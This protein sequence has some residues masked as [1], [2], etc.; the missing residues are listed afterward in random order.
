MDKIKPN[1][2]VSRKYLYEIGEIVNGYEVT[3]QTVITYKNSQTV[4]SYIC[5]CPKDGY[6]NNVNE[7]NLLKGSG[8]PVCSNRKIMKGVNDLATNRPDFIK[9]IVNK[10]DIYKYGKSSNKKVMM[11]CPDCNS[12]R[13]FSINMLDKLGKLPC[14]CSDGISYPNKFIMAFLEQLRVKFATEKRFKWLANRY[15]DFYIKDYNCIIEAHG[16][17]HYIQTNRKGAR[18]L[19]YEIA[20]DSLK[21]RNALENGIT[22]YIVLNCS[23]SDREFIKDSIL[24]S[25][26]PKLLGFNENDIDWHKCDEFALGNYA[27]Y[28]CELW[29]S[30]RFDTTTDLCEYLGVSKNAVKYLKKGTELGWCNYDGQAESEKI[31]KQNAGKN[32]G[33]LAKYRE[34]KGSYWQGR[35]RSE[36]T[37]ENLRMANLGKEWTDESKKKFIKSRTGKKHVTKNKIICDGI[38]YDSYSSCAEFYGLHL[39]TISNYLKGKTNVPQRFIDLGLAYYKD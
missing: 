6:I 35:N 16:E 39:S 22:D 12:E 5:K 26:V 33:S 24:S 27:K 31:I 36:A 20:N 17:Q 34:D 10:E 11:V 7:S 1:K 32:T 2:M 13:M 25:N 30:G 9:Y 28:V 38:I 19:E 8:C 37:K 21:K 15:Y 29:D 4:K 3:D 18:T 14:K 23:T